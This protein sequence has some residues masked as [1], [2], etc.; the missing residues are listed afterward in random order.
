M[1]FLDFW[2]KFIKYGFE[3]FNKYYS[4]YRGIVSDVED[5][6]GMGR[7]KVIVYE[8][9]GGKP[10]GRWAIPRN[11][12]SGAGYGI[13]C[14]PEK[15][16]LVWVEF[17]K[18]NALY[19]VWSHGYFGKDEKPEKYTHTKLYGFTT[20]KG[21]SV[22]LDD[23]DL[24]AKISMPNGD[25]ITLN[26]KGISLECK[27]KDRKIFFGSLDEAKEYSLMGE[28]TKKELEVE[29]ARVS[30]IIAALSSSPVVGGDGGLTYKTAITTALQP[31]TAPNYSK[32]LSE[33]VKND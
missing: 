22:T 8:V 2:L 5:P 13:Q 15:G 7:I 28:T 19:P 33:K 23:K 11:V 16:D 25:S 17:I 27:E 21:I 10:I 9:T 1:D 31:I 3:Y 12:Y 4:I 29:K 14:L 20:P 30:A 18:G 24:V 26:D 32:I 6:E